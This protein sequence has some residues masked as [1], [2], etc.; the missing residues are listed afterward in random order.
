MNCSPAAHFAVAR[1]SV[2]YRQR[3]LV[4]ERAYDQISWRNG[5]KETTADLKN[6]PLRLFSTPWQWHPYCLC[7]SV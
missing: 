7:W 6:R 2:R 4:T 3:N 1:V 5:S